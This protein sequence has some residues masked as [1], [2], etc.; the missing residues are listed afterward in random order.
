[1]QI[2]GL[3]GYFSWNPTAFTIG[4]RPPAIRLGWKPIPS[5]ARVTRD[6]V[7]GSIKHK[8]DSCLEDS[9]R[10]HIDGT[11]SK[12]I[13]MQGTVFQTATFFLSLTPRLRPGLLSLRSVLASSQIYTDHQP[14]PTPQGTTTVPTAFT[15]GYRPPAI[16]LGWKPIPSKARVTRDEVSGSIKHKGDSCLEDSTRTHIDGTMSKRIMMQGTVFQT[17]TFFLSLTPRLRPGLL[18]L[19]SVLASS[20]IYTNQQPTTNNL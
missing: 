13:M 4:Y 12:R 7:S 14:S 1:M 3:V 16:R 8:G 20:Q 11:M 18:S 15:V 17:A 10:T 19:R 2:Q 5:K 9:T 6:E